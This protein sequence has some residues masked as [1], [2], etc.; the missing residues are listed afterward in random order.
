MGGAKCTTFDNC[1]RWMITI[2]IIFNYCVF[3]FRLSRTNIVLKTFLK[4]SGLFSYIAS[5]ITHK[6]GKA[7]DRT[8]NAKTMTGSKFKSYNR[9]CSESSLTVTDV[10]GIFVWRWVA[11]LSA[12]FAGRFESSVKSG[13]RSESIKSTGWSRICSTFSMFWH[14]NR[15]SRAECVIFFIEISIDLFTITF[16]QFRR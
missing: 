9:N 1:C 16:E 11:V 5:T 3:K 13:Y 7:N 15:N 4:Y 12:R 14:S 10:F 2:C 8:M 6:N